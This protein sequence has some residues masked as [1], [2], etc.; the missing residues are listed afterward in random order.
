MSIPASLA[1]HLE[2]LLGESIRFGIP[3][4]RLTS[5]RIGGPVY[6]LADIHDVDRLDTFLTFLQEASVPFLVLGR[7][8]N[9]LFSDNGYDGVVI[10]LAG[11]FH[12][13]EVDG[14]RHVWAGAAVRMPRLAMKSIQ[15]GLSGLEHLAVI[16]GCVGGGVVQNAGSGGCE[17]QSCLDIVRVYEPSGKRLLDFTPRSLEMDYRHSMFKRRKDLIV[18]G[19]SFRLTEG[20]RDEMT[21]DVRKMVMNRK[22]TLPLSFPNAGSIFKRPAPGISPGRLIE[23]AGCKGLTVGGAMVSHKHANFIVNAG[24]ATS[25]DVMALIDMVVERVSRTCG[26]KLETEIEVLG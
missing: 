17:I 22:N 8:T 5:F 25:S 18:L 2:L 21:Y 11:S 12:R 19:A 1:K 6:G 15:K 13:I 4:S 23:D 16:P 24:N 3:A 10:R 26:I 7:G 14:D 9:V 20:D